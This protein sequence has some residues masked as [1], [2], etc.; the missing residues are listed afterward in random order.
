M[1]SA[2]RRD[3]LRK[4]QALADNPGTE[5]EG[6]AARLAMERVMATEPES[7]PQPGEPEFTFQFFRAVDFD[8]ALFER[9]MLDAKE[10]LRR[11]AERAMMREAAEA[12]FRMAR[13]Q[14]DARRMSD[15]ILRAWEDRDNWHARQPREADER[16]RRDA[17][18][19]RKR[20]SAASELGQFHTSF[21]D[22]VD[23]AQRTGETLAEVFER[24]KQ[25][26]VLS[27]RV[28]EWAKRGNPLFPRGADFSA[29]KSRKK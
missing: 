1:T 10:A 15:E 11:E 24:R 7:K 5:A 6:K 27:R 23:E 4:L 12:M 8:A 14:A 19:S 2:E 28:E 16:Q 26:W 21:A 9:A 18:E 13:E 22:A 3:K 25:E 20:A 17:D 29:P